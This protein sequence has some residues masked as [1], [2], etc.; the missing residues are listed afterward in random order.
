MIFRS[1]RKRNCSQKNTDT[2]Y[3][4]YSYSGIVPKERA[5]SFSIVPFS[6]S[7]TVLYL[8]SCLETDGVSE[9][10]EV[11]VFVVDGKWC[12]VLAT[13]ALVVTLNSNERN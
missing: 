4:E 12:S 13:G 10:D 6:S 9:A 3:S 5:H 11:V 1:L 2:V 7:C 8:V